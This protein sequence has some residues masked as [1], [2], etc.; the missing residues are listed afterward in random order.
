MKPYGMDIDV[1]DCPFCNYQDEMEILKS[2][3]GRV[4][5][6]YW[7]CPNCKG[8]VSGTKVI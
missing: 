1:M 6:F 2:Q 5:S 7:I 3:G 8:K 4:Q